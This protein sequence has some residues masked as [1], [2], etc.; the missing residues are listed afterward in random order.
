MKSKLILTA[1]AGVALA[2]S[3]CGEKSIETVAPADPRLE[4]IFVAAEPAGAISVIEARK[5]P[6]PGSEVTVIGRVAGAM[7]PFSKDFATLVLADDTVMTCD[8]EPGD[9]CETPWDACCVEPGVLAA[10][11]LLVQVNGADGQPLDATLKGVKG[12]KELDQIVI[13]GK[14]APGST[15]ENLIVEA[16]GIFRRPAEK[17][18]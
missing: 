8:R 15:A 9:T 7:E 14:V 17:S 5:K 6:E 4:A 16:S 1:F 12:L 13:Q 10:S 2:L 11:R 18:E 3:A